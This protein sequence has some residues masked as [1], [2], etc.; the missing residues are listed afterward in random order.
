MNFPPQAISLALKGLSFTTSRPR[1]YAAII[2]LCGNL[3]EYY[4]WINKLDSG[5]YYADKT[6]N[7]STQA[8]YVNY[9]AWALQK[10]SLRSI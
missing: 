6:F 5:M 2:N 10:K 9:Q 4:Y 7:L 1:Y 8:G 3:A